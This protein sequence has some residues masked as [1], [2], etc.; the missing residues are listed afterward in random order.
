MA[1]IY[2]DVS[3][4]F[5]APAVP[6]KHKSPTLKK[7]MQQATARAV[8]KSPL[9]TTT[10]GDDDKGFEIQYTLASVTGSNPLRCQIKGVITRL[11]DKSFVTQSLSGGGSA[12]PPNT[13]EDVA[14]AICE[15]LTARKVIPTLTALAKKK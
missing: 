12:T 11:P 6:A 15:D 5:V 1:K 9:F 8:N 7:S 10:K 14:Y 2:I 3:K 13:V 4:M